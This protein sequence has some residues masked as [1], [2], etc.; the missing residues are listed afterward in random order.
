MTT[1]RA[2][3]NATMVHTRWATM[4]FYSN[5]SAAV[6]HAAER[7]PGL[8]AKENKNVTMERLNTGALALTRVWFVKNVKIE[9]WLVQSF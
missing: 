7:F 2:N 9:A 4:V 5:R 1:L 8:L 6:R 3:R